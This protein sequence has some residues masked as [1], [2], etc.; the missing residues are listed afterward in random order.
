M[1]RFC[2]VAFFT[3]ALICL[4]L[5]FATRFRSGGEN[6][7]GVLP[8]VPLVE[9]LNPADLKGPVEP[10]PPGLEGKI[11]AA[12]LEMPPQEFLGRVHQS[13]VEKFVQSPGFG[14]SR[15]VV[16]S[17]PLAREQVPLIF[18]DTRGDSWEIEERELIGLRSGEPKVYLKKQGRSSIR[19]VDL[20][21]S[22]AASFKTRALTQ[23]EE[24]GIGLLSRTGEDFHARWQEDFSGLRLVSSLRATRKCLECHEVDGD[25]EGDLLGGLSYVLRRK[26]AS[27]SENG[28]GVARFEGL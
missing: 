3:L 7:P 10:L 17:P 4:G 5:S 16:K 24:E 18:V 21:L 8:L 9:P 25:R 12:L 22:G 13:Q 20:H 2:S 23:F 19:M 27:G 28:P 15:M 6:S 26:V 1:I 14:A 11:T